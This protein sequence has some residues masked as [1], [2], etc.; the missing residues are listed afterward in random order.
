M[1]GEF[2]MYLPPQFNQRTGQIER[3]IAIPR[4]NVF[5]EMMAHP[6]ATMP[7]SLAPLM[8]AGDNGKLKMTLPE[9]QGYSRESA[10]AEKYQI[11]VYLGQINSR[12]KDFYAVWSLATH[13]RFDGGTL[14]Q[15]ISET[16]ESRGTSLSLQPVAFSDAF[17]ADSDKQVQWAAFCRRL[18]MEDTPATLQE[19]VQVITA[20]LLPVTE[21]L[22]TG[23]LLQHR[24]EPD[25]RWL[26]ANG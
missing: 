19:V 17:A 14:A 8:P 12:L 20:F 6:L 4:R 24:W 10:I 9:V 21:A 7:L 2:T 15:A 3:D 18:H 25:G 1:E 11:M 23:Q 22:V 16:F 26:P 5:E 13:F